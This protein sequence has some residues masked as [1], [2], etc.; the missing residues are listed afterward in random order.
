MRCGRLV[1]I[2]KVCRGQ[3]AIVAKTRAMKS[4]LTSSWKRSLMLFTKMRRG[5]R[6]CAGWPISSG[7]SRAFPVQTGPPFVSFV[8]PA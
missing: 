7:T 1:R 6:H 4:S 5:A 2:W 8:R 3:S